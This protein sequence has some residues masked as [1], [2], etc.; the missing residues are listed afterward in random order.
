MESGEIYSN[1]LLWDPKLIYRFLNSILYCNFAAI[2]ILILL[3]L[4]MQKEN[5]FRGSMHFEYVLD[6]IYNLALQRQ[7]CFSF[8][9]VFLQQHVVIIKFI[10]IIFVYRSQY[11][12]H[13]HSMLQKTT[14]YKA[15]KELQLKTCYVLNNILNAL[16]YYL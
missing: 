12:V 16:L 11:L 9:Q 4:R 2:F 1:M 3:F 13:L 14:I 15:Q 5:P 6:Q 10:Y 7:T 8:S